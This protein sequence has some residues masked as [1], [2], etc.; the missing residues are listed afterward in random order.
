[1]KLKSSYD[2]III[3]SG[4]GGSTLA[5]QLGQYG[6]NVLVVDRGAH[7][8][9]S[10][11]R[12]T[13]SIGIHMKQ[14]MAVYDP[15]HWPVGGQTKFY[16]AALYRL[17]ESDFQLIEHEGGTSP[18][19]PISYWDL[20][21]YYQQAE[22]LYRVHGSPDGDPSEPPRAQPF[23]HPPIPHSPIV[24][25]LVDRLKASGANVSA[26]PRGIDYG[27]GGKCVLCAT[28]DAYY[29]QL[30]AKMDAEIAAL[31]PALA[32]GN[33]HLVAE[34]ECLRVLTDNAGSRAT[35]VLLRR[36]GVEHVVD[37]QV[38]ASSAGT[39]ES[40]ALLR[41][42]RMARH[43][44][45]LGN[46]NGCLGRYLAGHSVGTIFPLVSWRP[47]PPLHTKSFA[48]NAYYDGA[49]DWPYSL[50]VIQVAGQMPFWEEASP[51]IRPAARLVSAHSVM[52]FYMSEALPTYNSRLIFDGERLVGR[53]EPI[54]KMLTFDKLRS[55]ARE[56]FRRAGYWTVARKQAP[57]LW[58]Q[59]GTARMGADPA[60][61]VVNADCQVHGIEGLFILDASVLPSAGSVNTALTIMALSL[62]AGDFIAGT[63]TTLRAA[64]T[65]S[66]VSS[67]AAG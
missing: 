20:E 4:A 58:H 27:P 42:S 34:T 50:G 63:R 6:W 47:V 44:D 2:A 26:I 67:R 37:A 35:G 38:V 45:G 62:R 11:R 65:A 5:L 60:S 24:S 12:P 43:P 28:C 1:M 66:A 33:V 30:D 54:H 7:L 36:G 31:R 52:C 40:I 49:P 29:C 55:T 53:V 23:P 48:M 13:D 57:V 17:R 15:T 64:G 51:L 22:E 18:A 25:K 10:N 3:G 14:A 21:A 39:Q 46:D 61:S 59:V 9:P 41:R 32:T 8:T 56:T 19:W 16:G